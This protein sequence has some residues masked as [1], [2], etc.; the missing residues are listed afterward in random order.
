MKKRGSKP[1]RRRT[2]S[3]GITLG[4][5][6]FARISAVEGIK[7]SEA[8]KKRAARFAR[9]GLSPDEQIREV[10]AAHRKG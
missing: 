9:E 4:H 3:A 2:A 5:E 7:L 10:I 1:S 8:A 6:R